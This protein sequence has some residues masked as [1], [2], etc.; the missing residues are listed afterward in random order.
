MLPPQN[1]AL[2]WSLFKF[3]GGDGRQGHF[4]GVSF[5]GDAQQS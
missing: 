3:V 1:N 4:C 5:G 2:T